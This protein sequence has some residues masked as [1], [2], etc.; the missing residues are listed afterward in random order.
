MDMKISP[1]NIMKFLLELNKLCDGIYIEEITDEA[2]PRTI[3]FEAKLS[4]LFV[5]GCYWSPT[6]L[7]FETIDKAAKKHLGIGVTD[8][9]FNNT[10]T[11][12]YYIGA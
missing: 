11:I 5:D 2:V 12:F 7:F 10:R 4:S 9:H 1:K 8:F 3:K 6:N